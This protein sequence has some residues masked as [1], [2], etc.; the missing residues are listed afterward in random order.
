MA[1]ARQTSKQAASHLLCC[2][3]EELFSKNGEQWVVRHAAQSETHL[4][5]RSLIL[6]G[7]P[8]PVIDGTLWYFNAEEIQGVNVDALVYFALSVIWRAGARSWELDGKRIPALSLGP[9]SEIL[10]S[11]LLG[12]T[13]SSDLSKSVAVHVIVSST[14]HVTLITTFPQSK[15]R[16]EG[17]FEHF[18][19]V[20]GISFAVLAGGRIPCWARR[21]CAMH[22]PGRPIVYTAY[23]EL[24]KVRDYLKLGQY[25]NT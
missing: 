1:G 25:L 9:Y 22:G 6:E 10:R 13:K 4:P 11:Y 18:F 17:Y 12:E 19:D 3:C 15:K 5:L 16:P 7:L 14:K 20:P 21:F 8:T 2:K 23:A 24:A